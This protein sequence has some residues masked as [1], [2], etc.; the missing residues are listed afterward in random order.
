MKTDNNKLYQ[1][2]ANL[3]W[4]LNMGAEAMVEKKHNNYSD[5][6]QVKTNKDDLS[7]LEVPQK[8][9]N[10]HLHEEEV[11]QNDTRDPFCDMFL[12]CNWLHGWGA[13]TFMVGVPRLSYG[14]FSAV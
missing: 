7:K 9:D 10:S 3:E 2:V 6:V 13:Q 11:I 1:L 4:Q 12:Q 8:I 14:T 5:I